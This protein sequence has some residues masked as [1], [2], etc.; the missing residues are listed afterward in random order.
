MEYWELGF[1]WF[2]VF[3]AGFLFESVIIGRGFW[4]HHW[5]FWRDLCWGY[6]YRCRLAGA[7]HGCALVFRGGYGGAG[8]R[9]L[10]CGV[11][12]EGG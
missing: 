7:A 1:I 11:E 12:F 8:C 5:G 3:L 4:F 6:G 9:E 2:E 10:V